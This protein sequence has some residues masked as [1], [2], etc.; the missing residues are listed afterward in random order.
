[1]HMFRFSVKWRALISPFHAEPEQTE[2]RGV[3]GTGGIEEDLTVG[4]LTSA[5]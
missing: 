5:E 2:A 4:R 1:M 3:A